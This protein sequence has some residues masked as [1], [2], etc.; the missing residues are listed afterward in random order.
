MAF[1]KRFIIYFHEKSV[2]KR[3]SCFHADEIG[4]PY[5]GET[6][7]IENRQP[8]MVFYLVDEVKIIRANYIICDIFP[9]ASFTLVVDEIKPFLIQH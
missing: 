1:L 5:F 9:K 4:G 7:F 6:C 2:S 3:D 8:E